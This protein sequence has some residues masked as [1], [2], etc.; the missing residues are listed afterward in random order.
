[1][2]RMC[3]YFRNLFIQLFSVLA[4]KDMKEVLQY[5]QKSSPATLAQ[6]RVLTK[7]DNR[8]AKQSYVQQQRLNAQATGG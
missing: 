7:R 4:E 5:T 1:M 2:F 8:P 3:V 6:C